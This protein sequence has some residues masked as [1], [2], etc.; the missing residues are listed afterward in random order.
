MSL[1][2]GLILA[3]TGFHGVVT[4]GPTAPTCVAGQPCT[5]PAVGAVLVFSRSGRVVARTRAGAGGRY[6]IRLV[7]GYYT[8]RTAPAAKIGTGVSPRRVHVARGVYGRL[9]FSID[10]G[11]R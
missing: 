8:V 5:Q 3:L 11:I 6:A 9:D 1:A 4:R 2:L 10:T 7:P